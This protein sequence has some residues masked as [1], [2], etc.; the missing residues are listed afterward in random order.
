MNF[1][2]NK[3][4]FGHPANFT[5]NKKGHEHKTTI[6]GICSIIIRIMV[7]VYAFILF[8]RMASLSD[9]KNET[10]SMTDNES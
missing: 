5:F 7:A 9:N 3:D 6:G 1:I 4:F 8:Q 2:Q 10:Y